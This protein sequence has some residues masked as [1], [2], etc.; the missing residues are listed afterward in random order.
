MKKFHG[1]KNTS[2]SAGFPKEYE[3]DPND[4]EKI[5]VW[6]SSMGNPSYGFIMN[7]GDTYLLIDDNGAMN[8]VTH[9][10]RTHVKRKKDLL[11]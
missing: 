9:L 1:F 5:N 8:G 2:S 3:I 7:N 11:V 6:Y 4:I 10:F